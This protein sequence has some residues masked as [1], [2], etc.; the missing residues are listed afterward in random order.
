MTRRRQIMGCFFSC[1][2]ELFIG[3]LLQKM[4][5]KHTPGGGVGGGWRKLS[6]WRHLP[7][8]ST[9][10]YNTQLVS[11]KCYS[12]VGLGPTYNWLDFTG[13]WSKIKVTQRSQRSIPFLIKWYKERSTWCDFVAHSRS[14]RSKNI[15]SGISEWWMT[16]RCP[17]GVIWHWTKLSWVKSAKWGHLE[18]NPDIQYEVQGCWLYKCINSL[19][20]YCIIASAIN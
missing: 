2:W 14:K 15:L 8:C 11:M 17:P 16:Q 18:A 19:S 5:Q 12:K 9:A 4:P 7:V 10:C 20:Y 6:L 3:K 13:R 1:G